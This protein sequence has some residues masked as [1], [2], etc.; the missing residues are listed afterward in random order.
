MNTSNGRLHGRMPEQYHLDCAT[1]P[2]DE[3]IRLI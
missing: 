1:L 3:G 2:L